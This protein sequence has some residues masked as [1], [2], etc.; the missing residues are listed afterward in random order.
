MKATSPIYKVPFRRRRE[1]KTKYK[2][3]IALL[4]SRTPRL[5]VR[6]HNRDIVVQIIAFTPEGDITLSSVSKKEL[7]NLGWVVKRNTP[8]AYLYGLLIGK[9]AKEKGIQKLIL[10][11]GLNSPTKNN[12]CYAVAK[13]VKDSGVEIKIGFEFDEKRIKGEHIANYA[14]MLK[15]KNE[16]EYKKRFSGYLKKG[17]KPEEITKLFEETKQKILQK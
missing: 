13:G 12:I 1:G 16:E 5:V 10:D 4:K 17:I 15:E 9:K 8:T 6:K 14:K 2:R 3:R 11:M 7:E